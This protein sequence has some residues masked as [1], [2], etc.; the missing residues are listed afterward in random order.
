[1]G[2]AVEVKPAEFYNRLFLTKDGL[3][4]LALMLKAEQW[5]FAEPAVQRSLYRSMLPALWAGFLLGRGRC[6]R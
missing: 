3:V 5:R 2:A 1:M 6:R 4:G